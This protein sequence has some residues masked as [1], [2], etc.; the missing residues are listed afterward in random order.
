M[1]KPYANVGRILAVDAAKR[2]QSHWLFG[3]ALAV[4]ATLCALDAR[5]G[6]LPAVA[7][8]A[9]CVLLPL[10][11]ADYRV[12]VQLAVFLLALSPTY[13]M[14]KEMFGVA[15]LNPLNGA[16]VLAAA[17]LGASALLTRRLILPRWPRPFWLYVAVLGGAAIYGAGQVSRIPPYF[18]V[19]EIINF[20][21]ARG[22]VLDIFIKPMLIPAT[23]YMLSIVIANAVEPV[24]YL[25]PFFLSALVLPTMAI[26]YVLS[27]G[28]ALSTLA[29][30]DARGFLSVIG[31]HANE[32]G[33]MFNMVFSLAAF[34]FL[35]SRQRWQR[36][37]FGAMATVCAAAVAL[38]FSRG[39]YAGLLAVVVCVLVS[40]RR[41]LAILALMVAMAGAASWLPSAVTERAATGLAS[42]D[43]ENI[44]AGR[45]DGIWRPLLPDVAASP[46]FGHGLSAILWSDAAHRHTI[47]PVGHTH[48][49]YLGTLLDIGVLGAL[50][51]ALFFTHMGKLFLYLARQAPHAL[52][53]GFFRGAMACII[54]LLVQ[55]LTDDS[56]TPSRSQPFLWLSYG[57]G[58]GLLARAG[59][60]KAGAP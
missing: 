22:Y 57:L 28:E 35:S 14:P 32:L 41:V 26:G 29:S 9:M 42:G 21:S 36:L 31:M 39:A 47:L 12:A 17:S 60:R 40:Q 10:A 7:V 6:A 59:M 53:R 37:V 13:L 43:V 3:A 34:C 56:F 15:G 49:A 55:G 38:T 54:L 23:A 11:A 45:V 46:L 44:S 48:S 19:L 25:L 24:R 20:D 51:V 30:S 5:W 18:K 52:W 1:S 16:I 4:A 50:A 2:R 33:L 8:T 58:L 27:S